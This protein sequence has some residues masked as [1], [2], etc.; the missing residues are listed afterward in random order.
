MIL[1]GSI[2]ASSMGRDASVHAITEGREVRARIILVG[3]MV[4]GSMGHDASVHAI[5]EVG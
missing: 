5:T 1:V 4:A 3:L 2:G